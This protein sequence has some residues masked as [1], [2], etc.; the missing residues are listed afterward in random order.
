MF[1]IFDY[2]LN[3]NIEIHKALK[4]VLQNDDIQPMDSVE[5]RVSELFM[6]DFEKSGIH[7]DE[8]KVGNVIM[9]KNIGKSK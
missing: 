7:L 6:F 5:R 2:R 1:L 8:E 4:A 9:D 3:T